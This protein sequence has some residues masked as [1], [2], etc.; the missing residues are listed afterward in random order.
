MVKKILIILAVVVAIV[1][2]AIVGLRIYTK[3]FSPIDTAYYEDDHHQIEITYCRPYKKDRVIFP[4]LI[5]YDV[6]WRTGA[7]EATKISTSKDLMIYDNILPKG[8]YSLWTI[9][10]KDHWE[11]IFNKQYGHWGADFD[12]NANRDASQDIL[13]VT[14]PVYHTDNNIEQ[15]TIQFESA[16]DAIE[17]LLMWDDTI[18]VVPI[19]KN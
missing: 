11:V 1:A 12:S 7:N 2:L 15:F 5:P 17:M 19:K 16:G 13:S 9:P 6:V 18:V 3:S 4:D 14:V 8:T 10:G